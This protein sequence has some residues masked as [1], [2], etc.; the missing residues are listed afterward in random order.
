MRIRLAALALLA[1]ASATA[2]V[3]AASDPTAVPLVERTKLFG[4]PAR[5]QL[6]LS[7]DG[8][9]LSWIAPRDGVLNIWV[10]PAGDP[11]KAR[12]LTAEAQRPIEH[13][14]WAPASAM[15]LYVN[16]K[17]GDENFQ[18]FGVD[19]E[20]GAQKTLTPFQK[21]RAEI[22]AI[23]NRVKD[24]ILVGLNNRDPR[25]HDVYSLD[26]KTG[27]LTPVLQ[28]DGY[29]AFIAD[30]SLTLRLASKARAD[31]GSDFFRIVGGKV[32][33]KP[34]SS[35][36]L[37][38]AMTTRPLSF[39]AD[40]GTLYWV[41]SRG[42]DKAA[43][44]AQDVASGVGR[45]VAEDSRADVGDILVDPILADPKTGRMQAYLAKYL[46][47]EWVVTDPA[48]EGDFD[49]LKT[50]LKGE[51]SITSRTFADDR[52]TVEVDPA[53]ASPATYLYDRTTKTLSK[54]FVNRP[55]LDGAPLAAVH[56]LE[57]KA[58]D[59]LKLPSYLSLPPGSD[60]DGD[61]RP[62][63]PVPMVLLVHGGPWL[64]DSF[65]F[66]PYRQWLAN[67]DYAVLSVNFRGSSGFGKSFLSAGD[68]EWGGK[69]HADLIDA[70]DWAVG[71]GVTTRDKVAIMGGSYGGYAT[72]AGLS[73]TPDAFA[74]GI[75]VVGPSNLLTLLE[76]TP[77]HWESL[78]RQLFQRVGDP[79][80][81]TGRQLL[82]ERSPLFRAEAIRK[83][84][85][86]GQGAN[87]PRVKKAESDQIV[88]AMAAKNI[89]VTYLLFP[90]EGHG[91]VR[92][93]NNIAFSAISENFLGACLGGRAEPIGDALAGSSVLVPQ[94]AE[95]A[96]G[97][98]AALATR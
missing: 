10:A 70:V 44:V 74:C 79:T 3:A 88:Q 54:L 24:R 69:M 25:W 77:P 23:S 6:R 30:Q 91:F 14:V 34:F 50:R 65:G 22:I 98:G 59:G 43:V 78:K 17:G 20:S 7:P 26:L 94:G 60:A 61:G 8:R 46:R 96:P 90:D 18:L 71:S 85:L 62:E 47:G 28:N 31:G 75:D 92:P 81:E 95:F 15:I 42:R 9:W 33:A 53:N 80:T 2:T 45:V 93:E 13:H 36:G 19:V 63:R 12:P 73:F 41:D 64:R 32:E 5:M 27:K 83:P 52:W 72:L 48:I 39:T 1:T 87:D 21:T 68:R 56:P 40:G 55:D 49:L 4:N 89:P 51:I 58:R 82:R 11:T 38:D 37:E 84:L 86:I 16:D 57:I 66:D 97:L 67:R 76:S 35:I 29:A